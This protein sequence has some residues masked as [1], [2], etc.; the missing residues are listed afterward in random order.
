MA[1]ANGTTEE[2]FLAD[3]AAAMASLDADAT[4]DTSR[5]G[6]VGYCIGAR[7]VIRL[8]A[9]QPDVFVAGVGLHPSFC[10]TPEPDSPHLAVPSITGRLH[11]AQG[12]AD[13]VSSLTENQPL[14]DAVA[15]L[16]DRGSVDVIDGADHGFSLANTPAY[17]EEGATRS[18]AKAFAIFAEY[19]GGPA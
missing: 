17:H 5:V 11:L 9:D 12:A 18:Y 13:Q 15:E 14:L 8:L 3:I 4:V 16:G 19:I 6:C 7:T 1:I 10:V 2:M